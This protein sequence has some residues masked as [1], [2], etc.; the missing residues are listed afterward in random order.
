[1][2]RQC[3]RIAGKDVPFKSVPRRVSQSI[4]E[5]MVSEGPRVTVRGSTRNL[6]D[7]VRG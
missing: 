4:S 6:V 7:R 1:M 3:P 2:K 5:A